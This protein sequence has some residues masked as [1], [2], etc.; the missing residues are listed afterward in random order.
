[1]TADRIRSKDVTFCKE[2]TIDCSQKADSTGTSCGIG[3]GNFVWPF[4]FDLGASPFESIDGLGD[5]FVNYEIRATL[6]TAGPFSK[7]LSARRQIKVFRSPSTEEM[8][9]LGPEQVMGG[10]SL[11]SPLTNIRRKR[12]VPGQTSSTIVFL[13]SRNTINGDSR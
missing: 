6:A 12:I 2:R 9:D 4:E 5:S 13:H 7:K 1:M 3:A 10:V 11:V 8:D